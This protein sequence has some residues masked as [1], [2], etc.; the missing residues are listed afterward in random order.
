MPGHMDVLLAEAGVPYDLIEELEQVNDEF[1]TADV[2]LVIG[3]N[4][5]VNPAAR[6]NKA[7]PIYGMPIL[8]VDQAHQIYVIKRG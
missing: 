6:T 3:A 1:G 4:D 7:S 2:A 5:V 8:N